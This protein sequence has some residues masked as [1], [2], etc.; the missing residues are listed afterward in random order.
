MNYDQNEFIALKK[1]R[2]G[3]DIEVEEP[4]EKEGER[5]VAGIQRACSAGDSWE[6]VVMTGRR[7]LVT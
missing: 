1:T 6:V 7:N 3:L 4:E 5:R 2:A